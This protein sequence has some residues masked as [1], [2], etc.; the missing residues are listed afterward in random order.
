MIVFIVFKPTY[1]PFFCDCYID[2][3]GYGVED[4]NNDDDGDWHVCRN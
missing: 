4:D 3:E 2:D 1:T